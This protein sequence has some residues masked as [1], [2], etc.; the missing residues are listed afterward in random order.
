MATQRVVAVA[1]LTRPELESLGSTF[2]WAWPADETPSFVGLL[3]A[4]DEADRQLWRARDGRPL[5]ASGER[6]VRRLRGKALSG[7]SRHLPTS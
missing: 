2:D 4:I 7:Y 1:L 3:E 5:C 6:L